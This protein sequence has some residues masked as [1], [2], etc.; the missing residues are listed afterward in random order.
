MLKVSE[1]FNLTLYKHELKSSWKMLLI[2]AGVFT[3]YISMI[4]SMYDPE[5]AGI[6]QQLATSMPE[7]MAAVGMTGNASTLTGFLSSYLYGMLLLVFPMIFTILRAH[8][9]V[10]KYVDRGSMVSLL[11]APIKRSAVAFTQMKVLATGIL[12][13]IAYITVLELSVAGATFP[14][15]LEVGKILALN[16]G[17]LCLH[18]FIGGICFWASCMFSDAKY[19]IGIG[20]GVPVFMYIL[21]MLSNTGGSA[22]SGK[23]FTFF[24]LFNPDGLIEG[25]GGAIA[26]VVVL[27]IGAVALFT[28]AIIVFTKRDLHI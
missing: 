5:M 27:F 13:L 10:S 24:S 23:Y 9:L 25:D 8:G 22:E 17:L 3:L 2:F 28:S 11:A 7:I 12:A 4:I 18:L 6:L 15:E 1:I 14:N 20:A 21:Q 19:S 26:G 16:G